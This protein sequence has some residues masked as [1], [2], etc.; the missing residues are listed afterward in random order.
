MEI[1]D[2]LRALRKDFLDLTQEEFAKK[3]SLSRANI[4]NL[5]SGRIAITERTISDICREFNVNETWLR[6]GEGEIF[7]NLSRNQEISIFLADTLKDSDAE[8]RRQF[9]LMLTKL[10]A[11]DWAA[12]AKIAQKMRMVEID[13]H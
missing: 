8:F 9:V 1:K 10:D 6:T 13:Y 4:A 5:E 2:R 12:L 11:E 7:A 3:I